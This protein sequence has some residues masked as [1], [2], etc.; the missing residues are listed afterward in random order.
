ML[1]GAMNFPV[2][3]VLEELEGIAGLGFDFMELSMD[4]PMAHYSQVRQ[5]KTE[6][7]A[8][9]ERRRMQLVCHMPTFVSLADL[10]Q[11]IRLASLSEVL[12]SL[13][14]AAELEPLKVVVH[15]AYINGLG[16]FVVD[17]AHQY[18][19][20]SLAAIVQKAREL[21]L[22]LCLENMFPHIGFG[23]DPEDFEKI[24]SDYRGL[25]MTLD[26][27]HGNIGSP[28]GKRLIKL[29]EAFPD[30]IGH[31]HVSDNFGKRDDHLPI[32]SGSVRF[33]KILKALKKTG[34]EGTVTFEVFTPDRE[35]LTLSRE[36]FKGMWTSY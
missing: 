33:P 17:L 6:L 5:L 30:R 19:M 3:P 26:I 1:Y 21:G 24:F 36:K 10:T 20:Q 7:L 2:N 13:V 32:G 23:V 27:G 18:A 35:Y 11:S 14:A 8:A 15:P 16:T 31:L 34:Y 4:P 12:D 29:I 9:L 28:R 22:T 25:K